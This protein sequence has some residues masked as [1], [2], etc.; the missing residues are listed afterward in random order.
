LFVP[1]HAVPSVAVGFEHVPVVGSQ[2]PA[3][4]QASLAVHVTGLLPVHVP[5]WHAYARLHLLVPVQTVPFATA[6]FEQVPVV[7]LHV[8]ATWHG[9]LAVQVTGLLPVHVPLW[10]VSVCVQ[11]LPSLHVIPF[12]AVGFEQVPVV[13]SHVPAT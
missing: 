11:A 7:G 6:G 2:A 8:P 3:T 10:Q 5:L 12:A 9:S 13:E 4:W 1:V